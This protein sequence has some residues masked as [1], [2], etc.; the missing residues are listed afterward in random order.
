MPF[1]HA[2]HAP[3]STLSAGRAAELS[4]S[5]SAAL[6]EVGCSVSAPSPHLSGGEGDAGEHGLHGGLGDVDELDRIGPGGDSRRDLHLN[7]AL[8]QTSTVSDPKPRQPWRLPAQ[9]DTTLIPH[10]IQIHWACLIICGERLIGAGA[11]EAEGV[12]AVG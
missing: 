8:Q 4:P 3:F 6:R 12:V 9:P 5:K 10:R 7:T 2:F 11:D 1:A